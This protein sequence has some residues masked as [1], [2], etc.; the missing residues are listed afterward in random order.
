MSL[1]RKRTQR[2][3]TFAGGLI[4]FIII[5]TFLISMINP[6]TSTNNNSS[7]DDLLATPAPTAIVFPSP[8][9]NPQLDGAL[10]YIHSS[11]YFQTF[12]PA[13]NDWT[14]DEGGAVSAGTTLKVVMQSPQRL[15]VIHNYI[16]P[17]VNYQSVDSLS[18]D[19]L[20]DEHFAG[21]WTDYEGWQETNRTISDNRVL[22]DFELNS[23]GKT[24]L[25]RSTYWLEGDQ[26][27]VTRLVVPSNNP[28]LLDLLQERVMA[29]FTAYPAMMALDAFWPAYVDQQLGFIL[30]HPAEWNQVAGGVGRAVTFNVTA[31]QGKN[32][33]R[34]WAVDETPLGS[35]E[36][37]ESWWAE[38]EPGAT[39]IGSAPIE[40]ENGSG[41]QVAYTYQ[42]E[43][44]DVH[45][46]LVVLLN[47]SLGRLF[48]A[49]LQINPPDLN[50][51]EAQELDYPY[52]DMLKAVT[53]GFVVLPDAVRALP[54]PP[55]ET[56]P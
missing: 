51:L 13:G 35:A 8:N 22:V 21:A 55:E 53:E 6:G 11:G 33:V 43:Q 37:A 18:T 47:D 32:I 44:G 50:L 38:T 40:H 28:A 46:G 10:P 12:R 39:V 3:A 52:P 49:N 56:Q 29:T 15:V 23:E 25:N 2:R 26:L 36:E 16:Q 30:K 9:P 34:A 27:F 5:F 41:Y 17:G 14:I 48:A 4:G 19:F 42:D 31:E 1:S 7:D 20:T 45:S 24:Y 54:T